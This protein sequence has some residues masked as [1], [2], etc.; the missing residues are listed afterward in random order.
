AGAVR[1]RPAPRSLP[2]APASPA[3]DRWR[4]GG[5]HKLWPVEA[6]LAVTPRRQGRIF[7]GL[8]P[9]QSPAVDRP[10][11]SASGDPGLGAVEEPTVN[12]AVGPADEALPA[13][14]VITWSL[15]GPRTSGRHR[16]PAVS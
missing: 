14:A 1:L 8:I 10:G 5:C 9:R 16:R 2:P 12:R 4:C 6:G 15:S 13:E 11:M 7:R 3:V